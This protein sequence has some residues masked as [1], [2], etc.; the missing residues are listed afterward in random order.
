MAT[1]IYELNENEIAALKDAYY[2]VESYKTIM[3]E[4]VK[5][6]T[7]DLFNYALFDDFRKHYK[8]AIIT[9]DKEK[10]LFEFDYVKI[11]HPNATNWGATFGDN[12]VSITYP[13]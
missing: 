5:T 13:G 9:Y 1:K 8:E 2:E 3:N 10:I 12:K 7:D 6:D 4:L 11:K